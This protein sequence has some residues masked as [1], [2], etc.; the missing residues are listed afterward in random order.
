MGPDHTRIKLHQL[1]A[2]DGRDKRANSL[3]MEK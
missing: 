2:A 1:K 3:L